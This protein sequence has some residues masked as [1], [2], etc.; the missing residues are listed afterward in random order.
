MYHHFLLGMLI[1]IVV[2]QMLM[3]HLF[4]KLIHL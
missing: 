1:D 2:L 3:D 4:L